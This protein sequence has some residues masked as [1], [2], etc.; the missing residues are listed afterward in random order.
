MPT[1][2]YRCNGCE[3][4]FETTRSY[5]EKETEVIC[6]KCTMHSTRVYSVPAVQFKG[7]GFYSTGG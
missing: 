3:H 5:R 7:S 4:L 6:P 2:E 1:Y